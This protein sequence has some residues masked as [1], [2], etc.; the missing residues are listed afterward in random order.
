MKTALVF[1]FAL[2]AAG[3]NGQDLYTFREQKIEFENKRINAV[4]AHLETNEDK[5]TNA[6]EKYLEKKMNIKLKNKKNYLISKESQLFPVSERTAQVL[7]ISE[8]DLKGVNI[9]VSAKL[10][11]DL[12]LN[13]LN[14]STEMNNMTRLLNKFS[15]DYM[16]HE[17]K[18]RL[19]KYRS[20]L[21]SNNIN[22]KKSQ[23][24][25]DQYNSELKTLLK[26]SQNKSVDNSE[27]NDAM[28]DSEI[29]KLN[30]AIETEQV[31]SN[32]LLADILRLENLVDEYEG[33]YK[34][35]KNK[36]RIYSKE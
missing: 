33:K 22:L 36:N 6:L 34:I 32:D 2:L 7:V 16:T 8:R 24:K 21:K 29:E 3:V 23:K 31:I 25:V 35:V 5:L 28:K 20:D 4:G 18:N 14:F 15:Y 9:Y 19:A 27:D 11:P 13:S 10:G 30:K 17:I 12:Y 26:E 1:V